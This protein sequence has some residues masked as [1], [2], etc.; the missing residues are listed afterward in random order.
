MIG[1]LAVATLAVATLAQ[2]ALAQKL[3]PQV[4][5]MLDKIHLGPNGALVAVEDVSDIFE[6]TRQG[7]FRH[8]PS[9]FV[10]QHARETL[11]GLMPGFV[12]IFDEPAV[13]ENIGCGMVGRDINISIFMFR[14]D[15]D[16]ASTIERYAAP[17][18]K[19]NPPAQAGPTV[20]PAT[21]DDL[22]LSPGITLAGDA[23][24][25]RD[26][27]SQHVYIVKFGDW[28]MTGRLTAD[29]MMAREGLRHIGR[30]FEQ[31]RKTIGT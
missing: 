11:D 1:K 16:L 25:D 21:V 27:K 13:G 20:S 31:G 10:C 2:S 15:G 23:W 14:G 30:Q 19:A 4:Q 18:R 12:T 28:F 7:D 3:P 26:G 9:G 24:I 8:R 6:R 17:A 22:D 5:E 29:R